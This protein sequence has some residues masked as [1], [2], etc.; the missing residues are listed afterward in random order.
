[1]FT[2]IKI[3]DDALRLLASKRALHVKDYFLNAG[4][5]DPKRIFL[6]EPESLEP[7][8]KDSVNNSRVDFKLK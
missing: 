1:M 4:G 6:I 3:N 5:I 2:H 7:E 8:K